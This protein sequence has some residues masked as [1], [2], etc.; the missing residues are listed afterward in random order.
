LIIAV[1]SAVVVTNYFRPF[2]FRAP[3]GEMGFC[4]SDF[5]IAQLLFK[6]EYWNDILL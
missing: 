1:A 4:T 3:A 2:H 6:F 5:P